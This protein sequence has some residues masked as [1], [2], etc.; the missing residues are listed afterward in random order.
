MNADSGDARRAIVAATCSGCPN[1]PSRIGASIPDRA[2][3]ARRAVVAFPI[4]S[5][6]TALTRIRSDASTRANDRLIPRIV[7]LLAA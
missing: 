6:V 3:S 1:A 2:P 5:G 4:G 7:A